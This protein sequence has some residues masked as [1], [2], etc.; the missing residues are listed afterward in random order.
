MEALILVDSDEILALQQGDQAAFQ[1]LVAAYSEKIYRLSLSILQ[2][3]E[4]AEDVTQDVFTTVYSSIAQFKQDA[5]LSTW[6]YRITVNK[7]QE[8]IRRKSRKK[9]FGFMTSLDQLE[10]TKTSDFMHP[11]VELENKERAAILFNAINRLPE[12]QRLA[13]TMHKLEGIP[14]DEIAQIL[15]VTLASIESLLYRAKQ[16]LKQSLS[17]YYEENER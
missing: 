17:D 3:Q 6:M 12:N 10:S 14:Y 16:Q 2:H 7:C 15:N 9:R 4:D 8:L 5:Q 11:G 1:R 13:F